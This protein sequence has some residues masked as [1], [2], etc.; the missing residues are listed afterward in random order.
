MDREPLN[1]NSAPVF[2]EPQANGD[3][4]YS[5]YR[6][7]DLRGGGNKLYLEDKID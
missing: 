3:K 7:V 4:Q 6:L 2:A 1:A 5:L